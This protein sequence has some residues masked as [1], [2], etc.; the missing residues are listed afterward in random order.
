[1]KK[2]ENYLQERIMELEKKLSDGTYN[3]DSTVTKSGSSE[4]PNLVSNLYQQMDN[5]RK[6]FTIAQESSKPS[7]VSYI[8]GFNF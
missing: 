4:L 8:V 1:M 3:K 7:E 6:S 5:L 2:N